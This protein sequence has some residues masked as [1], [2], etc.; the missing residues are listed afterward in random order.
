MPESSLSSEVQSQGKDIAAMKATLLS[1]AQ[2]QERHEE[3]L[4]K[5]FS[6][7]DKLGWKLAVIVGGIVVV[8]YLLPHIF[9]ALKDTAPPVIQ[10]TIPPQ[11]QPSPVTPKVP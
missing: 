11:V 1:H 9:P 5:I 8:G 7:L 4:N 6:K 3:Y 10:V 2:T